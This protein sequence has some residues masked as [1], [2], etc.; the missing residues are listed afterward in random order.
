MKYTIELTQQ[1]FIYQTYE[2]DDEQDAIETAKKIIENDGKNLNY[3]VFVSFFRSSD[4]Q[5]GYLNPDGNH[6]PVGKDWNRD[7]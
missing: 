4:G 6:S 5:T 3:E 7:Q 2:C 1:G